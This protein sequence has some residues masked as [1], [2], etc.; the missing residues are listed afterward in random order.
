MT[1]P[2]SLLLQ[3]IC[4]WGRLSAYWWPLVPFHC[5]VLEEDPLLF[6]EEYLLL[7]QDEDCLLVQEEDI[8]LVQEEDLLLILRHP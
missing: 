5:L 8:L 1:F 6:Q 2:R 4:F 7:V 3:R